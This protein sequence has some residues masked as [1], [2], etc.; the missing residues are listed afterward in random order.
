MIDF[1]GVGF[2]CRFDPLPMLVSYQEF[3][4]NLKRMVE[5]YIA[6]KEIEFQAQ[7]RY[8]LE[9]IRKRYHVK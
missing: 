5:D 7:A 3:Y 9:A 4:D 1:E 8:Y 2:Y 6:D